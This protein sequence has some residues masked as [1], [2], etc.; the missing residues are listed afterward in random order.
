MFVIDLTFLLGKMLIMFLNLNMMSTYNYFLFEV[1]GLVSNV[2]SPYYIY[3]LL[4][5]QVQKE[6]F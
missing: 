5:L 6:Y 1:F 2:G 3:N 4:P